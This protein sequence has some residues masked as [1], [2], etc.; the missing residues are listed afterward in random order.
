MC[1]VLAL[2]WCR[3]LT[4]V[5]PRQSVILGSFSTLAFLPPCTSAGRVKT[6][7]SQMMELGLEAIGEQLQGD[8]LRPLSADELGGLVR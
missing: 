4:C 1:W 6:L 5:K 8:A 3:A 2:F 7:L